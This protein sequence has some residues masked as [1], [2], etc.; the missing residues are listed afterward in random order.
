[1]SIPLKSA[2]EKEKAFFNAGKV[3][4]LLDLIKSFGDYNQC[5]EKFLQAYYSLRVGDIVYILN[6]GVLYKT[7][8]IKKEK[9]KIQ[10]KYGNR[11]FTQKD[12]LEYIFPYDEKENLYKNGKLSNYRNCDKCAGFRQREMC[13]WLFNLHV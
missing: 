10:V 4:G 9:K 6:N 8:V 13:L 1:M 12:Y 5:L 11:W 7:T 2:T 3:I